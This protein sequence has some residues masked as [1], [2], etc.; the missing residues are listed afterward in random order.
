M[1]ERNTTSPQDFLVAVVGAGMGGLAAAMRLQKRGFRVDLYEASDRVGG[2]VDTIEHDGFLMEFG[3]NTVPDRN[4]AISA[5]IDDL[6][7]G[8]ARQLPNPHAR[9][10][11][12]VRNGV[13][14]ALPTSLKEFATTPWLSLQAKARLLAEPLVPR[15]D[16]AEDGVTDESLYNLTRRR[17]GKEIADYAIDPFV[18]GTYGGSPRALSSTFVLSRLDEMEREFGSILIGAVRG[19][20]SSRKKAASSGPGELVNFREGMR[21]LPEAMASRLGASLKLKTLITRIAA[22]QNGRFALHIV[23]KKRPRLYDG[24][25]CAL[26]AHQLASLSIE[27]REGDVCDLSALA[28]IEHP[29]MSMIAL[30]YREGQI[31]HPLDGFGLLVPSTEPYRVLGAIFASTLFEGRA[32]EGCALL[33]TFLGGRHPQDALLSEGD[34]IALA[35]ADLSRMLGI[36]GEPLF[37]STRTWRNSIPQYEVGYARTLLDV[38]KIERAL[39]GLYLTGNWRDGI[40]VA[41]VVRHARESAHDLARFLHP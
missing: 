1:I 7:I 20:L 8:E 25:I 21:T 17:L 9:K 19:A 41:D 31:A 29:P 27:D 4:G 5:L 11:Y 3:P 2:L 35:T 36:K 22:R 30:G 26:S 37:A 34:Q 28:A 15:R 38:E 24:V 14:V 33:M 40:S 10:R 32:P 18:A 6:G 12:I 16:P 13:P 23:G 39:P